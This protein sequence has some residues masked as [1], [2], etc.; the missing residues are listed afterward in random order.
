MAPAGVASWITEARKTPH[1]D[2]ACVLEG[3]VHYAAVAYLW[4]YLSFF[5]ATLY[6]CTATDIQRHTEFFY[7]S[8]QQPI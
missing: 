1:L 8:A 7:I 4:F 6:Q 2:K 3:E 5:K